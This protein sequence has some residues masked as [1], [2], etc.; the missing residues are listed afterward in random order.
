M[1][2][3]VWRLNSVPFELEGCVL[4]IFH[5]YLSIYVHMGACVCMHLE[6]RPGHA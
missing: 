5:T 4:T 3:Q 2:C 1:P 6:A